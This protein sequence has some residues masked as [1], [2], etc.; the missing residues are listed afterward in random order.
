M[1]LR[2]L[3]FGCVP[4][5]ASMSLWLRMRRRGK[6]GGFSY[7]IRGS[8]GE[9]NGDSRSGNPERRNKLGLT[10]LEARFWS[11]TAS[12]QSKDAQCMPEESSSQSHL[13]GGQAEQTWWEMEKGADVLWAWDAKERKMV[14]PGSDD[15]D[16]C[17]A[18]LTYPS[19]V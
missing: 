17:S 15:G 6:N 12:P 3:G 5:A 18:K 1:D 14:K 10:P 7:R 8:G 9:A 13:F 11:F 16:I 2:T 19:S 4:I